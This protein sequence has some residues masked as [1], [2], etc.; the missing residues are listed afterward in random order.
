MPQYYRTVWTTKVCTWPMKN[1][2]KKPTSLYPD[3]NGAV[4]V[5]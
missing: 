5:R 1:I 4:L 2:T 3:D